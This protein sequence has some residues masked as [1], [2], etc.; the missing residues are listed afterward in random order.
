MWRNLPLSSSSVASACAAA[1][2]AKRRSMLSGSMLSGSLQQ[3][4]DF[5]CSRSTL[6]ISASTQASMAH[7]WS[8]VMVEQGDA[9]G[10]EFRS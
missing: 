2:L 7:L 5:R 8:R 3:L 10:E 1:P 4:S 6:L 9:P